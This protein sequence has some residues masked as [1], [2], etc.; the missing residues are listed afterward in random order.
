MNQCDGCRAGHEVI[1]KYGA[2]AHVDATG[3]MY[4]AC[5][6]HRYLPQEETPEQRAKRELGF[7]IEGIEP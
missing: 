1:N 6:S 2:R 7:P 3:Y 5:Q 4:M